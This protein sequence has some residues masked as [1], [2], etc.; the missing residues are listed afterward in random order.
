M[1]GLCLCSGT[2]HTILQTVAQ[3]VV[4]QCKGIRVIDADENVSIS[5]VCVRLC[6]CVEVFHVTLP[7]NLQQIDYILKM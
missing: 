5:C 3:S 7:L 4:V 6:V 2:V 1:S